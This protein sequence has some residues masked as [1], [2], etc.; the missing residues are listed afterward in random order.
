MYVRTWVPLVSLGALALGACAGGPPPAAPAPRDLPTLEAELARNPKDAGLMTRVG[1]AY[2]QAKQYGR[3]RD[4]LQSALVLGEQNYPARVYLGLTYEELGQLDSARVAYTTAAAQAGDSRRKAEIEDR[5]VL[6]T[7]K[8]LRAAAKDAIAHEASLT[9]QPPIENAVA[10]LP[11]RYVGSNQDLVPVGRGLTHLMIADLSKLNRLRLL[12]REQ[13]QALVDEMAM[14]E[15][16]RV[17]P[18]TGARSGRLLRAGRVLQGS[19]QDGPGKN[20]LRLDAT[21]VNTTNAN[22]VATGSGSD[23]LQQLFALQK[24]VLFRLVEQMGITLSPAEQRALSERP[25][26]D[27]Q[28]FLAFSR[29]LEAEDRGDWQGAEASYGA[30]VARDPNF[31]AAKDRRQTTQR[32]STT[33]TATPAELAGAGQ[34]GQATEQPPSTNESDRRGVLQD[35]VLNT[36]PS[37]GSTLTSR[38]GPA[39]VSRVPG[40]RP[41]LP[42]FLGSDNPA[43]GLF[44]TIIIIITRP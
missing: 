34:G 1:I 7:R 16:G 26:A 14:T 24:Q 42:E 38:I 40:T 33:A 20:D 5:L 9:A 21:V 39:P 37:I 4:V 11:F 35:G 23:R 27:L 15:A 3:A 10:V 17:D 19:V 43:G 44:G 29:G 25:T 30:A 12:E 41:Q 8:E 31:R 13:V 18:A 36:V 6:L 22:V 28:A 32:I 2:Y